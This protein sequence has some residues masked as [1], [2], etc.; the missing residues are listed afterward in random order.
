MFNN[1]NW[2]NASNTSANDVFSLSY[3]KLL[4]EAVAV[5]NTVI[6]LLRPGSL[7]TIF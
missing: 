6:S 3:S 2:R 4:G 5:L 1:D 7:R